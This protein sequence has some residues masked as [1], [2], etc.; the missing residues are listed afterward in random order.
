[1]NTLS[2]VALTIVGLVCLWVLAIFA[3]KGYVDHMSTPKKEKFVVNNRLT[4]VPQM[5]NSETHDVL[6]YSLGY[7]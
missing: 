4:R 2:I 6:A 1:M 5:I 7:S 3:V